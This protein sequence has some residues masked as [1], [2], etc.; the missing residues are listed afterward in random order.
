MT[1]AVTSLSG[2]RLL[3]AF[4]LVSPLQQGNLKNEGFRRSKGPRKS[5]SSHFLGVW[6]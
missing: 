4:E 5:A 3:L 1:N 6:F 2:A